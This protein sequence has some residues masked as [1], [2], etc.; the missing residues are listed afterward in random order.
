MAKERSTES[1]TAAGSS[2]GS[3]R[4]HNRRFP[5]GAKVTV[6]LG[7][8]RFDATILGPSIGGRLR[9]AIHLPGTGEPVVSTYL[10]EQID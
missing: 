8:G 1:G 7:L 4:R 2:S 6:P 5:P 9:V 10:P 3:G